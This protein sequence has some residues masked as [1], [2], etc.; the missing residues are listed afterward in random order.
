[1]T[2]FIAESGKMLRKSAWGG[3]QDG[4]VA[5]LGDEAEGAA[6]DAPAGGV[7]EKSSV[8]VPVTV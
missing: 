1:M 2:F 4:G 3:A 8:Y 5:G 7:R 6:G